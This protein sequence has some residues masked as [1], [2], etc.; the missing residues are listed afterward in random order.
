MKMGILPCFVRGIIDDPAWVREFARMAEEEG[1]ES[2]WGVEHVLV[3]EDYEPNY[4]YSSDGRMPADDNTVMPDPLEWLAFVAGV[5]ERIR[6]GTSVVVVSQHSPVI[7]AK[8]LATLDKLSGGRLMLG[9]GMGWQKE[10]YAA[11]GIPYAQRGKRLDENIAVL[12]AL[13]QEGPSSFQGQ[14]TQFERVH[15]DPKPTQAGG[16]PILIG[17]SGPVAA[18]RAGRIGD[19]FYPYVISPEDLELR[20]AEM[21]SAA[22]A[23][24]RDPDAIE[25]TVW[26][27]SWR[28][29]AAFDLD[30]LKRYAKC[31]VTR[32]VISAFESS[33]STMDDFRS[34]IRRYRELLGQVG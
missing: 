6:L 25:L 26:P 24:G 12:R 34:M 20:V 31:G 11:L 27:G 29:G 16:V 7:L 32:F 14:F 13:W 17:G 19:G 2:I 21:R 22:Q 33:G 3:A 5:T 18:R 15:C 4:L 9:A 1:C 30:V 10:E 28:P 8:R 23:A